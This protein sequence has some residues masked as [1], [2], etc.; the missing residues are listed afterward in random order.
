MPNPTTEDFIAHVKARYPDAHPVHTGQGIAIHSR[1]QP[2]HWI[3]H[4]YPLPTT[5]R[6]WEAAARRLGWVHP[7]H[8][9]FGLRRLNRPNPNDDAPP[10][11]P[12]APG[13]NPREGNLDG[14]GT[15]RSRQHVKK[16]KPEA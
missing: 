9:A 5:A 13:E 8:P 10:P 3:W 7:D 4:S 14:P 12:P 11:Q 15:S 1:P 6:A 2:R 16:E